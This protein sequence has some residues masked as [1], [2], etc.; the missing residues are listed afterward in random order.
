[1]DQTAKQQPGNF[2]DQLRVR[3]KYILDPVAAFLNRLG[4]PPNTMTILGLVG[5]VIGGIFLSQGFFTIGGLIVLASGPFDALDGAMA[6]LL[7]RSS[8]F[9]GFI[10][11]VTDRYSEMAIL[12]GLLYYYL[13]E[14]NWWACL[15]VYLAA[16]GS[17]MVSYVRAKANSV[18][19][20]AKGGMLTRLERYLV[21]IPTLTF[22]LPL[23]GVSIIALFA[24]M[25]AFQRILYVRKQAHS[26]MR[27]S[28]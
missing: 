10:D 3:F 20:E 2:T 6:R 8:E 14:D 4:I 28:D 25:T 23:V 17:V 26:L 7:G 13:Q 12:G 24:N 21:L 11:S 5:N 15:L 9:G 18:G 16:C 1:M 19:F 22:N 27:K